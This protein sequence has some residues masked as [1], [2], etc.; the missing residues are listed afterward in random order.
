MET[1]TASP[2]ERR[3][4][5]IPSLVRLFEDLSALG[6]AY[7]SWKSNEHLAEAL[8]GRTDVDLLVAVRDAE[9]FRR[10]MQE[11]GVRRLSTPPAK[12]YP[13]M[14]HHL[15]FDRDDGRLFHLH[16]HQELVLGEQDVKNHRVPIEDALLARTDVLD[17]VR[18]P[19]PDLELAVLV[20]RALL[21]YRNRDVVKDVLGIRSPG[22]GDALARELDWLLARTSPDEVRATLGA[23]DDV[24]PADVV[25]GFLETYGR[26]RRAGAAFLAYRGRVRAHLRSSRRHGRV[27][28]RARATAAGLRLGSGGLAI[29]L[30]GADGSGKSTLADELEAWLGWK[31][32]VRRYYLGSK[33][34]SGATRGS[35]LVFRALRRGHRSISSTLG[36]TSWPASGIAAARDTALAFHH[37]STARDRRRR[38]RQGRRDAAAGRIVVF[39]RFPLEAV[40]G[41][42]AHRLLDGPKIRQMPG[43]RGPVRSALAALEERI[44]RGFGPP[45]LLFVLLVSPEVALARKPDHRA[46]VVRAKTQV[47]AEVAELASANGQ[48]GG[49]VP[50]DADRPLEHVLLEI[51]RRIWD[52]F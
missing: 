30:V 31:L 32:D 43:S 36:R 2:A 3:T 27:R 38:Y 37:L 46:D 23:L 51:Q 10:S 26:D 29:A 4:D 1:R 33:A 7:C 8:A 20:V 47:A 11:R 35:Y 21:K 17:G 9:R 41:S 40:S 6:I 12:T 16:V 50:V 19:S 22:I 28:A 49:I 48:A 44:Y 42:P 24:V 13:G 25:A 5:A 45:D 52:A 18:V 15:G 39:D 14:E 34:P